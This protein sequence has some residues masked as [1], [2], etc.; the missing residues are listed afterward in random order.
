M[1][2]DYDNLLLRYSN[3]NHLGEN[4]RY[5]ESPL[6]SLSDRHVTT[7]FLRSLVSDQHSLTLSKAVTSCKRS[8]PHFLDLKLQLIKSYIAQFPWSKIKCALQ[9]VKKTNNEKNLLAGKKICNENL[10]ANILPLGTSSIFFFAGSKGMSCWFS[11]ANQFADIIG[12]HAV[13]SFISH[14]VKF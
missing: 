13:N 3:K 5:W 1:K 11:P 2:K 10:Q 6:V 8:Q 4:H 14:E 12:C 9:Y 7:S